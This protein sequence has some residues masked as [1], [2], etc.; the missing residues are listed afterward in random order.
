MNVVDGYAS[1]DCVVVLSGSGSVVSDAH[2]NHHQQD[3]RGRGLT[4]LV[5]LFACCCRVTAQ[6][7]R[8]RA[9]YLTL[10]QTKFFDY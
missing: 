6:R 9:H 3:R 5:R 8:S 2:Q 1:L 4:I 10:V 7:K